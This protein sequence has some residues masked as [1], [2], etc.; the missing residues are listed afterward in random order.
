MR[1]AILAIFSLLLAPLAARAEAIS[2]RPDAV[3]LTI[4]RDQPALA[5]ERVRYA[6][7]PVAAVV[8][9]DLD[10][11]RE[12]LERIDVDYEPLPGVLDLDAALADRAPL[13][14]PDP[15][16]AGSYGF[17]V[18]PAGSNVC[19]TFRLRRG[20]GGPCSGLTRVRYTIRNGKFTAWR[21]LPEPEGPV[22]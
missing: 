21:Q 9:R 14:H 2:E 11:A 10:A 3:A 8:A 4:Y 19:N 13:V 7:E 17:A 20:P 18:G 1:G 15:R 12:A 22:V 16:P 6:G 5:V